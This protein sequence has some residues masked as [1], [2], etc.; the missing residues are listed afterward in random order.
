MADSRQTFEQFEPRIGLS[1]IS[2]RAAIELD[3]L[4][5][6]KPVGVAFVGRLSEFLN[7]LIESIE[8]GPDHAVAIDGSAAIIALNQAMACNGVT[9]LSTK[10]VSSAP[11]PVRVVLP[12]A[13]ELKERFDKVKAFYEEDAAK[14]NPEDIGRL[15]SFCLALAKSASQSQTVFDEHD[16]DHPF[17]R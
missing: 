16:D 13:Q 3:N 14:V 7:T 15:R 5:S 4:I 6:E 8:A 17:L 2:C 1:S 10:A 11:T 12:F 9:S